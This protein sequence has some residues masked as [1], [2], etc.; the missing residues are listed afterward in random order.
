MLRLTD[1][2]G[3]F[4][5]LGLMSAS[6]A[7]LTDS[8]GIQEETTVLGV[9]CLTLRDNTERPA[10][11]TFGTNRLV[12]TEPAAIIAAWQQTRRGTSATA[13]PPLWDGLAAQRIVSVL[14]NEV[15]MRGVTV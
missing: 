12:G 11:V 14:C 5:F 9:P 2:L 4:D 6:R 7:V 10:T 1:P 8:G 3:Y 15:A 13:I